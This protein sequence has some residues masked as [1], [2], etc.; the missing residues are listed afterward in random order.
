MNMTRRNL[1]RALGLL[2]PVY[3]APS[4]RRGRALG[5]A[6]PAIPQRILFFYT[7]HGT[8]FRQW[9]APPAGATT[10][11][12]ANYD[13]GPI[14]QPLAK[15]KS[16]LTLVTGLQMLSDKRDPTTAANGHVGGQTQALSAIN[17]A[18]AS[19]AGGLSIDQFIAKNLTAQGALTALPSLELSARNNAGSAAFVT[20]WAGSNQLIAPITKPADAYARLFPNGP[21]SSQGPDPATVAMAARRK[22]ILDAAIG[23]F[24][25][26]KQP[27]SAADKAK[28]DSHASLIRD[29]EVRTSIV[30]VMGCSA[31][32]AT[33]SSQYTTDCP[34]GAGT[35]CVQDAVAA[36]TSL[37]VSA[38]ACDITRVIT[39]DID[40]LPGPM[41]GVPDIHGFLHG[42]DDMYWSVNHPPAAGSPAADPKN[43]QTAV[44][45]YA[46]Y[47]T[48]MAN[49]LTQLDAVTEPDGSTLLDHTMVVW[50]GEIGSSNHSNR[51]V[52]YAIAG[53]GGGGGNVKTGSWV[54]F[55]RT[56]DDE[57][58]P[59][60][61]LFVS[62][63][64]AMGLANVTKFG[65]PAVCT[66]P[67]AQLRG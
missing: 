7:P 64:N 24:A 33:V 41:F 11:T 65:N 6:A 21:P 13:F 19:A 45:F 18:N 48:F 59:H 17:R 53:G 49:L 50:C 20:S 15:F 27:L 2:G 31:P 60:N 37:A 16:K 12:A 34:A 66:G 1:L 54:N 8:L 36:F 29:L 55:P 58:L 35:A 10:A 46:S 51:I 28:L 40:Q 43:I 32:P 57:G 52:N 4:L 56:A 44:K 14:L 23:E 25:A 22:S 26:V 5:A 39:L 47:A 30:P 62:L 38:F 61:N 67:L 9:I 3:F 42:M 63:A